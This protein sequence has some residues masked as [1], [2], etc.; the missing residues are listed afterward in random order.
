MTTFTIGVDDLTALGVEGASGYFDVSLAQPKYGER[1]TTTQAARIPLTGGNGS[2]VSNAG[3]IIFIHPH[4]FRGLP[5]VY[6]MVPA[7]DLTLSEAYRDH[8]VEKGSWEPLPAG[9]T[10]YDI[11]AEAAGA[12][13]GAGVSA[14]GA[15]LERVGAEAAK[16]AALAAVALVPTE[17]ELTA[18]IAAGTATMALSTFTA[19]PN[20]HTPRIVPLIDR[21]SALLMTGGTATLVSDGWQLTPSG[22]SASLT[23]K[24]TLG[25]PFNMGP[26]QAICVNVFIP[27]VSKINTITAYIWHD[28][29]ATNTYR[30]YRSAT[31]AADSQPLVNGLNRLRFSASQWDTPSMSRTEWH[32]T[33]GKPHSMAL[34]FNKA[35]DF[36]AL[37]ADQKPII[38]GVWAEVHDKAKVMIVSDR[39]YKSWVDGAYP[40]LKALGVP[41]TWAPDFDLFG[42]QVGTIYESITETRMRELAVENGNSVSFHGK[43]GGPTSGMTAAQLAAETEAC[44]AWLRSAGY[45]GRMWRA[46]YV[47]N[48]APAAIDPLV[49]DQL[50]ASASYKGSV[51]DELWPP[52]FQYDISRNSLENTKTQAQNAVL[53]DDWFATAKAMR[54]LMVRFFHRLDATDTFSTHPT[55]WAYFM[56]RL[57]A[58]IS[59]GWMEAV[60]FEDLFYGSG[61]NFEQRNGTAISSWSALP[62]RR[63]IN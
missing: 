60:T 38:H 24:V 44:R 57:T 56:T 55:T 49:T 61:G 10:A 48:N 50:I 15:E 7:G 54:G 21:A 53:V 20:R 31:F 29:G 28:A 39:G 63:V 2:W 58:A 14:A 25:A 22:A 45:Q 8:R 23:A 26:A 30:W 36:P 35:P 32:A 52:R 42:T 43:T 6:V 3:D 33:W 13:A 1:I 59:E 5:A 9:S 27:D 51:R 12:A 46:A 17:A 34:V 18:T 62:T 47:Q 41:V 16:D 4:G 40:G 19:D 11:L 37:P